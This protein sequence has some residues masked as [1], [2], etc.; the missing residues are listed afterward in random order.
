M[1]NSWFPNVNL[2]QSCE[3]TVETLYMTGVSLIASFILG[4]G[5]G[6]LLFLTIKREFMG[7]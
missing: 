4:I 6:L 1:L 3:K 5:L 2:G 7:K